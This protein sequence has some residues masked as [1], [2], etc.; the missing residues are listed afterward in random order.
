MTKCPL[1]YTNLGNACYICQ[2]LNPTVLYPFIV[3]HVCV[4][5]VEISISFKSIESLKL[6]VILLHCQVVCLRWC[7]KL[8][9]M[10]QYVVY[11]LV[12]YAI[13]MIIIGYIVIKW[14]KLHGSETH[15]ILR[16]NMKCFGEDKTFDKL[17][18]QLCDKVVALIL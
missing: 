9:T 12:S 14:D 8:S 4:R 11:L 7:L 10:P 3:V 5:V 17:N 6:N 15:A 1:R 16:W 13:W 18:I 2:A